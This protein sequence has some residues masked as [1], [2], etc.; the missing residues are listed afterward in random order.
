MD[1][2]SGLPFTQSLGSRT[3]VSK[4]LKR[5]CKEKVGKVNGTNKNDKQKK[6]DDKMILTRVKPLTLFFPCL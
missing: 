2:R 4:G 5:P 6:S 3:Y 1:Q